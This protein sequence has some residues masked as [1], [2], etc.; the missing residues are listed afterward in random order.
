MDKEVSGVPPLDGVEVSMVSASDITL[1]DHTLSP[2]P[3]EEVQEAKDG[4]E[5]SADVVV[6]DDSGGPTS[7]T[8]QGG[9]AP[10]ELLDN[11]GS[12][13]LLLNAVEGTQAN[14]GD[15]PQPQDHTEG[16]TKDPPS[17]QDTE[18]SKTPPPSQGTEDSEDTPH[19]RDTEVSADTPP[20]PPDATAHAQNQQESVTRQP[21]M[22]PLNEETPLPGEASAADEEVQA[23]APLVQDEVTPAEVTAQGNDDTNSLEDGWQDILGSGQLMKKV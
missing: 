18:N 13:T 14:A 5:R 4:G 19:P 23:P 2:P 6:S 17:S 9:N 10:S 12:T 3:E 7:L 1:S 15:P 22:Q 16:D 11:E 8:S 20:Q 21:D